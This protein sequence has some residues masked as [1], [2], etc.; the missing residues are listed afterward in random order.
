ML[1]LFII[2]L[3]N[4][5][6]FYFFFFIFNENIKVILMR[7]SFRIIASSQTHDSCTCAILISFYPLADDEM[8]IVLY[9][10]QLKLKKVNHCLFLIFSFYLIFK[11]VPIFFIELHYLKLF[12]IASSIS[13]EKFCLSRFFPTSSIKIHVTTLIKNSKIK[14]KLYLT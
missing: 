5:S 13:I 3:V 6:E 7:D 10:A 4:T 1:L 8:F 14:M 11:Y 9:L 12:S 2:Y